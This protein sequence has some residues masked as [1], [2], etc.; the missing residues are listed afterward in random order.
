MVC[1]GLVSASTH[2]FRCAFRPTDYDLKDRGVLTLM[3]RLAKR[4]IFALDVYEFGGN[5]EDLLRR[6][7]VVASRREGGTVCPQL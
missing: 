1:A 6:K 4:H 2:H 3:Y 7:F 5:H